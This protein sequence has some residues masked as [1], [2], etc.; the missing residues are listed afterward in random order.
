MQEQGLWVIEFDS[1]TGSFVRINVSNSKRESSHT[2]CF[3]S[4]LVVCLSAHVR[5]NICLCACE[6]GCVNPHVWGAGSRAC[7]S[8][9]GFLAQAHVGWSSCGYSH[10]SLN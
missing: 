7:L 2:F 9:V 4:R 10:L 6:Y 8:Q 1:V 3:G 5:I